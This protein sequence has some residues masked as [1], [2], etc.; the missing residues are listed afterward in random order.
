MVKTGQLLS[1]EGRGE[2]KGHAGSRCERRGLQ[3]VR[4][5]QMIGRGDPVG[6]SKKKK[7]KKKSFQIDFFFF[8][9]VAVA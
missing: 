3:R 5:E 6:N 2:D 1:E 7:K 4:W 8:R 9:D